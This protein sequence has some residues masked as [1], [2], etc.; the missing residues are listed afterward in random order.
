MARACLDVA[1]GMFGCIQAPVTDLLGMGGLTQYPVKFNY[2]FWRKQEEREPVSFKFNLL[3]AARTGSKSG[4][5]KRDTRPTPAPQRPPRCRRDAPAPD[6]LLR[7]ACAPH[8][9]RRS[10]SAGGARTSHT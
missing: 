1:A 9:P 8:G 6:L 5:P 4:R 7:R 3:D 10:G 2:Q